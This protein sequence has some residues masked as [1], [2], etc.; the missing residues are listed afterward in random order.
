MK[1]LT[2][3]NYCPFVQHA[4]YV[5]KINL[6]ILNSCPA[7]SFDTLDKCSLYSNQSAPTSMRYKC[8]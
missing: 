7:R 5:T 8:R 1:L 3:L 4:N 2:S 6:N